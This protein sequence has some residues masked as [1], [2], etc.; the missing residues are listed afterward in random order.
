MQQLPLFPNRAS[1]IGTG[2]DHLYFYLVGVSGFFSILIF[3]LIFVFAIKYRRRSPADRAQQI[4]GNVPLELAW[5]L[6]PF[7]LEMIMFFWG[8]SLYFRHYQ[9]PRDAEDIYVVGKQWMWKLQHPEGPREINELHVPVGRP[10]RLILASEDVI[11][12]FY[13]PAFRIK[14]DAV[15]G[16]YTT[17]W[18]QATSVGKYHLFC[19]EYC[20]TNHSRMTGWI[21][22][23]DPGDYQNWLSGGA[24][25]ESMAA[26]GA[27]HFSRL[28]CA[29]CH[30]PD[31]SG[32]GPSLV[33]LYGSQVRLVGGRTAFADDSYIRA[34]IMTPSVNRVAN[35]PPIMPTFRGVISEEELSQ[36]VEYIKSLNQGAR[37]QP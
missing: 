9:A 1:T 20:G 17:E 27:R 2:V 5:A 22:V 35:Y 12:S 16:M 19:A 33:G 29:G 18:F 4:A 26:A 34:C 13:V 8:A 3:T 6:I 30:V 37:I 36:I 28:G 10:F 15:P 25:G 31:N 7:G 24:P 21:Y 23:M 32:R 11:H 14:Q